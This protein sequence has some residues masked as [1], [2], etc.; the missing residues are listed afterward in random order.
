MPTIADLLG[1]IVYLSVMY[2]GAPDKEVLAA[3]YTGTQ[4]RASSR[5]RGIRSVSIVP[6]SPEPP[7]TLKSDED[8][9]FGEA[10]A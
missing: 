3:A 9:S 10:A 8:L 6:P 4:G 7:A 5:Y 1:F 2:T